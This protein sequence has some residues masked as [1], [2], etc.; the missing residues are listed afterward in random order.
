LAA[1]LEREHER[2]APPIHAQEHRPLKAQCSR[3]GPLSTKP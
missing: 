2:F 1:W 3:S